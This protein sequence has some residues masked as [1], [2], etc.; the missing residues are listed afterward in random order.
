MSAAARP[1]PVPREGDAVSSI[2]V[3]LWV[4]L[5]E[6][7]NRMLAQVRRRLADDCTMPRFDLEQFI[8]LVV[9]LPQRRALGLGIPMTEAELDHWADDCVNLFVNGCRSWRQHAP[10]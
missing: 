1:T 10:G 4:R 9:T 5:L 2:G 3:S 7:H 6:S 8:Q